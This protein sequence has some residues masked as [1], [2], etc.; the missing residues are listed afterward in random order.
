MKK[1]TD[2]LKKQKD[3][4]VTTINQKPLGSKWRKSE[5]NKV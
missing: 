4:I 3:I 2:K 5:L 1:I